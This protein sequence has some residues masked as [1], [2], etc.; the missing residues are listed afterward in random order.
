MKTKIQAL[1][2]IT[3]AFLI[4]SC[5]EI[6]QAAEDAT[7]D[8]VDTTVVSTEPE[9]PPPPPDPDPDPDPPPPP[10]PPDP[11]PN[12]DPPPPPDP[13]PTPDT[14][15]V[16]IEIDAEIELETEITP[17]GT[18]IDA[19]IDIIVEIIEQPAPDEPPPAPL[20]FTPKFTIKTD[21]SADYYISDGITTQ[22]W[23]SGQIRR[24]GP[25]LYTN[26]DQLTQYDA[27]ANPSP[28][29]TLAAIPT[30]IKS[31]NDDIYYCLEYSP[32]ESSALGAQARV[33]TEIYKREADAT[34]DSLLSFFALNQH[35]CDGI[36]SVGTAVWIIDDMGAYHPVESAPS[37]ILQIIPNRFYIYDRDPEAKTVMINGALESYLTNYALSGSQWI[38]SD[39]VEYSESGTTWSTA[40]GL[41]ESATALSD[42]NAWPY[43]I[44]PE[45][46]FGE[47]PVFLSVGER[48]GL[49]YWVECNS[50]WLFVY[51]PMS[52]DLTQSWRLYQGDGMHSTGINNRDS[53]SPFLSGSDLYFSE[54]G[55]VSVL[56]I[57]SGFISIFYGGGGSVAPF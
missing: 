54:P 2:I 17:D 15:I 47:S 48:D 21:A 56:D 36:V 8:A 35:S 29:V 4:T 10:P 23:L 38:L 5:A 26:G 34:T 57:D 30:Q 19:T 11:D 22:L 9:P 37:D 24:A 3:L 28:P 50:G 52:D 18:E 43:P 55:A 7:T 33:H 6:Q 27:N 25:G 39:G 13:E 14:V 41:I 20:T 53:L 45:L 12:P 46:P 1:I 44:A 51:D 32:A 40:T 16:T 49:L 42:F 31:I